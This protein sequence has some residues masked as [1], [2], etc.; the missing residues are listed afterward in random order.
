MHAHDL[1][2]DWIGINRDHHSKQHNATKSRMQL[3]MFLAKY[4]IDGEAA[5]NT[6]KNMRL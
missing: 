1:E 5:L 6:S 2:I 4:F 3:N